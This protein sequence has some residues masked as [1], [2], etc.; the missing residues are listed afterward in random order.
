MIQPLMGIRVIEYA[1]WLNGPLCSCILGQFGAEVIKLEPPRT[2]DMLRAL[3]L[4]R[5]E[6]EPILSIIHHN[7]K[8]ITLDLKQPEGRELFKQLIRISD[9]FVENT[10]T[11]FLEELGL[12][13]SELSQ[14]NPRLIQISI[15]G[16]G[17]TGPYSQV[18]AMDIV[19]QAASGVM[20]V[21]GIQD[22]VP[23]V[24]FGDYISG[25][26]GA[27][28]A[29]IA[30]RCRELT[31][32]GQQIDISMQDALFHANLRAFGDFLPSE[33]VSK[34]RAEFG[35]SRDLPGYGSFK[36]KD[37]YIVIVAFSEGEWRRLCE[38]MDRPD[39]RDD[40][41]FKDMFGRLRYEAEIREQIQRWVS[42][43]SVEELEQLLIQHKIPASI[44]YD[45]TNIAKHPQ[46]RARMIAEVEHPRLGKLKVPASVLK[47]SECP[48]RIITA[49]PDLGQHN[50]EIYCD[51]LGISEQQLKQLR[52]RGVI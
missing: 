13:Y 2:G 1:E 6:I 7:K 16:F 19:S 10:P 22:R 32:R 8:S 5:P 47:L 12:G 9:I 29:L 27:L 18:R 11:G 37:G 39:L 34:L 31:G 44:V 26:Y 20:G 23:S 50:R 28:G 43:K 42:T 3:S 51:L 17:R 14:L 25:V 15:S 48:A 41:R 30:L 4:L 40:P 33:L 46:L 52:H 36:A 49:A 35:R 45:H 24:P 21:M 38:L